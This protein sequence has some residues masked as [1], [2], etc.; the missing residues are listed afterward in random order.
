MPL[1]NI[2]DSHDVIRHQVHS[3]REVIRHHYANRHVYGNQPARVWI[4]HFR[5]VIQNA[6]I[7]G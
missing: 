2:R 7:R 4:N 6:G 5:E 3:I 1:M